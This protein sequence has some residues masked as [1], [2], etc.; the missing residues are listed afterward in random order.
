MQNGPLNLYVRICVPF[1]SPHFEFIVFLFDFFAIMVNP[2]CC[3][4]LVL[5]AFYRKAALPDSLWTWL[6][7]WCISLAGTLNGEF[8]ASEHPPLAS[9]PS[10]HKI[11]SCF[12]WLTNSCCY[13]SS[14]E[15]H[16]C[17]NLHTVYS[18]SLLGLTL[19]PRTHSDSC[20]RFTQKTLFLTTHA[21][22]IILTTFPSDHF[23]LF[24][25]NNN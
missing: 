10:Q 1:S 12:L 6:L 22:F 7:L 25:V 17:Q 13:G 3:K 15:T 21:V 14:Y 19:T 5:L 24:P 8:E 18:E 23:Y 9:L 2:H 20:P 4:I 11:L 16:C